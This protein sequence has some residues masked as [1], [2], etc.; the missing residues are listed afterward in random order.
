MNHTI[1]NI[2]DEHP[3]KRQ[4][5]F[6]KIRQYDLA[7]SVG[8]SQSS[9]SKMLNGVEPMN[10]LIETEIQS[11]LNYI[12]AKNRPTKKQKPIVKT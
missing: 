4:I 11:I 10:Q 9:L 2:Y 1:L 7:R 5:N 8:I 3:Y 12:K 6:Y